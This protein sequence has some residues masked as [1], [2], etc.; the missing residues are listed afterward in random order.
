MKCESIKS[1]EF[2]VALDRVLYQSEYLILLCIGI[3]NEHPLSFVDVKKG[4]VNSE[5]DEFFDVEMLPLI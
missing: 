4:E 1:L 3:N 2:L 5:T